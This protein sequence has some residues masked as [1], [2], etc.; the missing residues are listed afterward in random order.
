MTDKYEAL[1]A[2]FVMACFVSG[3]AAIVIGLLLFTIM[4]SPWIA[5]GVLIFSVVWLFCYGYFEG[6]Y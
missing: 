3:G 6:W 2:S 4:V 5:I 1:L